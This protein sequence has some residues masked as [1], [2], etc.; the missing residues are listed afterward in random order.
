MNYEL[1]NLADDSLTK[2]IYK[3]N[4]FEWLLY[5]FGAFLQEKAKKVKVER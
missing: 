4:Y 1:I 5:R 3:P 2:P